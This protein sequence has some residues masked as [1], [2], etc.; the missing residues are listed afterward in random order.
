MEKLSADSFLA[1][2][3]CV[4]CLGHSY[5]FGT[6][7]SMAVMVQPC[8]KSGN[9]CGEDDFLDDPSEAIGKPLSMLVTIK[10]VT[11]ITPAPLAKIKKRQNGPSVRSGREERRARGGRGGDASGVIH[12]SPQSPSM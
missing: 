8:D 5:K 9:P 11:G 7:G 12:P 3:A 1:N 10:S 4:G 2:G 6:N